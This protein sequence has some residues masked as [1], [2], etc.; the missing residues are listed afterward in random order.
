L[1]RIYR[2]QIPSVNRFE[3]EVRAAEAALKLPPELWTQI[4]YRRLDGV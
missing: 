4:Q 1:E 3:G 2:I